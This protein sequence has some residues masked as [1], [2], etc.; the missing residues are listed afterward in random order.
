M[1]FS[2]H[3]ILS[4]AATACLAAPALAADA[5]ARLSGPD[6]AEMGTVTL[7]QT[8]QGV[9]IS[10]EIT[11]LAPGGHGFHIHEAGSCAPDFG[12]AGG[13]F[14]PGGKGHGYTE[15]GAHAGDMPNI[16]A[17]DDGKARADVLNAA[18]SLDQGAAGAL[19]DGDGS[20]IIVHESP[21]SYGEDAMAGG[22]VACGVIESG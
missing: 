9:L 17:G 13:H 7:T 3:L 15:G 10:A 8:P 6:G 5:V 14:N 2:K 21:D 12:A 22:R 1:T 4:C 18:V 16:F 19:F 20:A 11:G